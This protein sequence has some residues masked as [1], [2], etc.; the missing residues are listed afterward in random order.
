MLTI[1]TLKPAFSRACRAIAGGWMSPNMATAL[2]VVAAAGVGAVFVLG[3]EGDPRLLLLAPPLLLLRMAFNALDGLLAR[4]RHLADTRGEA[5]NELCDVGGDC[6][7]YLPVAVF[8]PTEPVRA[9]AFAVLIATLLAEFTGVV[10]KAVTGTRRYEGPLGG[11]SDRAFWFGLGALLLA[12]RPEWIAYAP[13]YLAVVLACVVVTWLNRVR[14]L[15][16]AV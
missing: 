2:G 11:K 12:W 14:V 16:A 9:M 1:Y 15:W 5:L 8:A 10:G 6:L 7:S 13:H 3:F 4:E